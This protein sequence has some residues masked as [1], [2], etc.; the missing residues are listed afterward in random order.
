MLLNINTSL[1]PTFVKQV[2]KTT[3]TGNSYFVYTLENEYLPNLDMDNRIYRSIMQDAASLK[4]LSVAP[5]KS[6]VNDVFI[7]KYA[8]DNVIVTEIVEGTMINLFYTD[9]HGWNIATRNGIGGD[10]FYFRTQYDNNSDASKQL[11]PSF[12]QMFLEAIGQTDLNMLSGLDK[13]ICY[14]FVLQHPSNH[15]VLNIEKPRAV[16]VSAYKLYCASNNIVQA[17][18][19]NIYALKTQFEL[20]T[21]IVERADANIELYKCEVE[22]PLNVYTNVGYMLTHLDTGYRTAFYNPRYLEIKALRGNNPNLHYQYLVLRKVNK[23]DNFLYYFPQYAEQF[24][25][26]EQHFMLYARRLHKLYLDVHV[27]KK[28]LLT[29]ITDKRDKYH[30]EKIHYEVFI[31]KLKKNYS[32]RIKPKVTLHGV[33]EYLDTANVIV[34][35]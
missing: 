30:I 28:T 8:G 21:I 6:L 10:Y 17:E 19:Q 33:M 12:K 26:F 5:A 35:F 16:L 14:S 3:E 25:M 18:Y 23:V 27:F 11:Q 31:P 4:I 2:C 1:I 29:D 13:T 22:N 24:K 7:S 9:N 32:E 20:P 34:P 15:I